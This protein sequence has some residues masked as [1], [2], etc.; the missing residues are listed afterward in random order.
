[1]VLDDV[2][3]GM[4]S[5]GQTGVCS[6]WRDPSQVFVQQYLPAP[7]SS[8]PLGATPQVA[9]NMCSNTIL[10]QLNARW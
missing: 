2:L 6:L 7:Y 8:A 5:L 10:R 9:H 3:A 4:P 1:M